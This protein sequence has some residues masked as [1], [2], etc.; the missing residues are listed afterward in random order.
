MRDY[1]E[2]RLSGRYVDAELPTLPFADS[3]FDLALCSHFLFLY[4]EQL[5]EAF[6]REAMEEMCRVAAGVRIFPLLALG[7]ERSA[8]VDPCFLELRDS[9]FDV[10]IDRVAYEFQRGG[11]QMMRIRRP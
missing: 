3:A 11:D 8:Y 2:G 7:R 5:G 6:H 9:G 10:S 4:T 1:E